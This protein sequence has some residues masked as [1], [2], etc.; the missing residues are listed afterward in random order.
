MKRCSSTRDIREILKPKDL[1]QTQFQFVCEWKS[2]ISLAWP[3]LLRQ[4]DREILGL[5]LMQDGS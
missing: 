3:P 1:M 5:A 2:E 4:E